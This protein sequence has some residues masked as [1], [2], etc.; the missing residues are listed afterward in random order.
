[1]VPADPVPE[2]RFAAT[3]VLLRDG[4]AGL[5]V[6]MLRRHTAVEFAGDA[7]VFPGGR[8]EEA[9]RALPPERYDGI[10]PAGLTER[11]GAPADLVLGF[12][13]AAVRETFEEAGLLF[14]TS[15]AEDT[16]DSSRPALARARAALAGDV[17]GDDGE[18]FHAWLSAQGLVLDLGRLVY[19]SRWVT[20]PVFS[21]RFDAAFFLAPAPAGQVADHDR[22]ETTAGRWVGP[23]AALAEHEAGRMSMM[24]PT[25]V[26]LGWLAGCDDAAAAMRRALSQPRVTPIRPQ[27]RLDADGTVRLLDGGGTAGGVGSP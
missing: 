12:H 16:F 10:D 25:L 9:D 1:M 8:V 22:L 18:G 15:A 26:T 20:P 21:K 24:R 2:P 11:F 27:A 17:T 7:W 13:V 19:L 14:V 23:S 4:E 5:E 6:L 3:V